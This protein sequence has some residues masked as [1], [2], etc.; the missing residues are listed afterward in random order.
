MSRGRN[1]FVY[2]PEEYVC[3]FEGWDVKERK[4]KAHGIAIVLLALTHTLHHAVE[5]E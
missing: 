4:G 2:A 1:G 3:R 5:V